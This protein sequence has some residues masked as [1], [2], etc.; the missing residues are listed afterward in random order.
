MTTRIKNACFLTAMLGLILPLFQGCSD[1]DNA[2][3][4]ASH[5]AVRLV[6]NSC[7]GVVLNIMDPLYTDMQA[8]YA[9][10]LVT[11]CARGVWVQ[12]STVNWEDLTVGQLYYVDIRSIKHSAQIFCDKY[13][14]PPPAPVAVLRVY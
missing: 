5:V 3:P 12:Q 4:I 11:G 6:N 2:E 1:D 8:D 7:N 14:S 10:D 9:C 13:P